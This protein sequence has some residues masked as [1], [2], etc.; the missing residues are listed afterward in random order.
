[1]TIGEYLKELLSEKKLHMKQLSEMMGVR[2]RTDLYRLFNDYHGEKK[3]RELV[4]KLIAC[5]DF[6]DEEIS[7]MQRLMLQKKVSVFYK[8]TRNVLSLVY[9]GIDEKTS[10]ESDKVNDIFKQCVNKETIVYI[11]NIDDFNTLLHICRYLDENPEARVYHYIRVMSRKMF[12]AYELAMLIILS[13]YKNYVPV[14]LDDVSFK[15]ICA[16]TKKNDEYGLY[17]IEEVNGELLQV[18]SLITQ[19]LYEYYRL[20]QE[21]RNNISQPVKNPVKRVTDYIDLMTKSSVFEQ[22][23]TFY[24]EG[25]PCFGNIP[26]DIVCEMFKAIDYF[27]FP[28]DHPYVTGMQNLYKMRGELLMNTPG[29]RKMYLFDDEH[30]KNM[31]QTGISFD[32]AEMFK[33]MTPDQLRRY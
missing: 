19:E 16:I 7:T 1:M 2:N 29:A 33:P 20:R 22:G 5:I 10:E 13:M 24:S 4:D 6:T 18:K 27:G 32:H 11:A 21:Q 15:G 25:A 28:E 8:E 17:R 26:Y 30:I 31:M 14:I 9:T 3:T 23:V 12:T